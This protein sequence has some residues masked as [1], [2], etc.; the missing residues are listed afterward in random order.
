M[1]ARS[2]R[3]LAWG[4]GC[5]GGACMVAESSPASGLGE[6]WFWE[7]MG[8]REVCVFLPTQKAARVANCKGSCLPP[9]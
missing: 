7:G 2:P 5:G 1:E 3:R 6:G 8:T 9:G 4:R